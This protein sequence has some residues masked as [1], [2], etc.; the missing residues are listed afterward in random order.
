M[1]SKPRSLESYPPA[2]QAAVAAAFTEGRF[3]IPV[4]S[5]DQLNPLRQKL[6]GYL[7]ALRSNGQSI[8]ADAI[9]ISQDRGENPAVVLENRATGSVAGLLNRALAQRTP[10]PVQAD[11]EISPL[12]DDLFQRLTNL[13]GV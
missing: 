5:L 7:R 8:M 3:R 11:P 1:P 4:D 12:S 10:A 6:Y 9:E 2:F 13:P